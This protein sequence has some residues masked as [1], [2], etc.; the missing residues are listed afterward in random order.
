MSN[1][2]YILV[3]SDDLGFGDVGF[4]GNKIIKTPNLDKM[5]QEGAV[6]NNFY[7]G[8][9]VCSPTRGTCLTGRHYFRFGIVSANEGLLP[10]QEITIEQMLKTKGYSTGHFGKWHLGTL[11]RTIKDG[12]RGGSEHPELY[13]PP[14]ERGFDECF[15][16]EVQMP[17]YN[18][19]E[20]QKISGK[21]WTKEGEYATE[22]LAGDDSRVIMDR[23][24]PFIEKNAKNNTPFF[25]VIWFHAPHMP[26]VAGPEYRAMYSE[27]TEDMQHYFGCITAMDEQIGRL[28]N[29]L[30]SL[31][32]EDNTCV[33]Y[34][35]DNGPESDGPQTGKGMGSTGG[36]RGRKRSLF[37]GGVCVPSC[38][39]WPKY[40]K[41]NTR[42]DFLASTL[43]FLPTILADAK[44]SMPD[45]RPID[46]INLQDYFEG[47]ISKRQ[48][49][50]PL[51]FCNAL[52]EKMQG[53]STFGLVCEDYKILCNLN[54]KYKRDFM[55][56][57]TKDKLEQFNI[58]DTN[59]E[60]FEEYKKYIQEIAKSFERSHNGYDYGDK[61]YKPLEE[62]LSNNK[63][64]HG[65]E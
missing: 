31:G 52:E 41:P 27:Y 16:S 7:S 46:G 62:Y 36:L 30:K 8:A 55:F 29:T 9:P 48:K 3:M 38:I 53:S 26:V 20:N 44:I 56:S 14:W 37:N 5:A 42:Y 39:K 35:S 22:N 54:D 51:R 1:Q 61:N 43:D 12:H 4:N 17:S 63:V 23:A 11:S 19:M 34:C 64:W 33:W 57:T 21:Y 13:A 65:Q 18:P 45:N 6:F 28:N 59:R 15:S 50:I 47:K 60:K 10:K 32:I 58:V 25:T 49:P 24:I 40:I 2:N